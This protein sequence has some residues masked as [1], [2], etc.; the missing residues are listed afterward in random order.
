MKTLYESEIADMTRLLE[1]TV[2]DFSKAY[3]VSVME[4]LFLRVQ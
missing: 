4:P 1:E 3:E 2:D